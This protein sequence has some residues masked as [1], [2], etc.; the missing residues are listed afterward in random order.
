MY[1]QPSA[2][3]TVGGVVDDAIKLYRVCLPRSWPLALAPEVAVM[4]LEISQQSRLHLTATTDPRVVFALLQSPGFVATVVIGFL[5]LLV[6]NYALIDHMHAIATREIASL[7]GSLGVGLRM[8]PRAVVTAGLIALATGVG[9]VLL[10]VPGI[11]L[12]GAWMLTFVAMVVGDTGVFGSMRA[13]YSLIKGH[14]W[15]TMTIYT[16]A[17]LMAVVFYVVLALVFGLS[18]SLDG[19]G[20]ALAIGLQRLLS[21]ALGTLMTLW[22][23]AVLL[24]LYYD[25]QLRRDGADLSRRIDALPT[26]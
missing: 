5:L 16:V 8:L 6:F 26:P 10:L 22:F 3:K 15:R 4:L 25:L 1:S 7:R 14:W 2:P 20:S 18:G 24:S 13:S 11:Y 23:P 9:F 17:T 12:A 19:P 21:V